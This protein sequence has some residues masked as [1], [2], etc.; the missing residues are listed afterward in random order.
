[1]NT[2]ARI[3]RPLEDSFLERRVDN[4]G[5]GDTV[6]CLTAIDEV[7]RM[8]ERET[9]WP[10]F[11]NVLRARGPELREHMLRLVDLCSGH[12]EGRARRRRRLLRARLAEV[13]LDEEQREYVAH[14]QRSIVH[15]RDVWRLLSEQGLD[16]APPTPQVSEHVIEGEK[17]A[18]M[19][20]F[21]T[22]L[23]CRVAAGEASVEQPSTEF[24]M[25]LAV[26]SARDAYAHWAT[27][28]QICDD[29]DD[30]AS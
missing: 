11:I 9:S 16:Q 27:A 30:D 22:V 21:A 20:A 18:W 5:D 13:G 26:D 24:A 14:A 12:D 10:C 7:M 29:D 4:G 1:M 19:Y 23:L 15:A 17:A 8:A 3:Q 6:A 25:D 28:L 2:A